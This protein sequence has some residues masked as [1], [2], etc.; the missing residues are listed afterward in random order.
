M[1]HIRHVV[2]HVPIVERLVEGDCTL[3]HTIHISNI[4]HVPLIER[5]VEGGCVIKHLI[6]NPHIGHVPIVERLVEVAFV[7]NLSP[8]FIFTNLDVV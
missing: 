4:G 6:H 7:I 2:G 8:F 3:K 5:L 1:I